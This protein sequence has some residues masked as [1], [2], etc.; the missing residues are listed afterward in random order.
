MGLGGE[1]EEARQKLLSKDR[2]M[3]AKMETAR[4]SSI[5]VQEEFQSELHEKEKVRSLL[6]CSM[7]RRRSL[8]TL[9][10]HEKENHLDPH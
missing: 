3:A 2:E 4:E 10:L 7:R 8:S 5:R 6:R 1:Q 9:M